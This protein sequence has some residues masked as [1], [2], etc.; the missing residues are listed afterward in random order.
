MP[1][2]SDGVGVEDEWLRV[3]TGA[4]PPVRIPGVAGAGVATGARPPVRV[5]GVAGAGVATR[6]SSPP[7]RVAE[8]RDQVLSFH[9][10][11][12]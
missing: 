8:A 3:A 11:E 9:W 4:R 7:V 1:P 5:A 12:I 6:V 10:K 2:G